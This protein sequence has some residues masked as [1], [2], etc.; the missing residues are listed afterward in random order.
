[1]MG[2][3]YMYILLIVI[4]AFVALSEIFTLKKEVRKLNKIVEHLLS[5]Q[6]SC[7]KIDQDPDE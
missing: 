4:F 6:K 3:W 7:K 1:M 5:E 2:M